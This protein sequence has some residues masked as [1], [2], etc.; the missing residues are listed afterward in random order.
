LSEPTDTPAGQAE[1]PVETGGQPEA[2]VQQQTPVQAQ[3]VAQH[4]D[5]DRSQRYIDQINGMKSY[6]DP[7][8]AA[9][10]SDPSQVQGLVDS[11]AK[12]KQLH[13]RGISIDT[14]LGVQQQAE[15]VAAQP[16]SFQ[17]EDI[18]QYLDNRESVKAHETAESSAE[19][20]L[21][22]VAASFNPEH[23]E[24]FWPTVLEATQEYMRQNGQR[25]PMGHPL[26]DKAFHPPSQ[27]DIDAIKILAQS[28]VDILRGVHAQQQVAGQLPSQTNPA[29]A[30][31]MEG[32]A[33]DAGANP[34]D[35]RRARYQ[36]LLN[37][38]LAQLN[39]GAVSN[40]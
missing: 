24:V 8:R 2:P 35:V 30:G 1:A 11:Q 26:A 29:L 23:S 9:G 12:L 15:P 18:G 4:P 27:T 5:Q 21:R 17:M 39:G 14:L 31:R 33:T 38:N 13:D 19:S 32:A 7:L 16:Q 22:Q 34:V 37:Q 40:I 36:Q 28:K 6:V 20:T 3:P 25:Y 10:I